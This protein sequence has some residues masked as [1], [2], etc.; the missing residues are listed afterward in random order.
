MDKDEI[1]EVVMVGGSTKTPIVQQKVRDYF[2]GNVRV[3]C[4]FDPDTVV[5]YGATVYAGKLT[6]QAEGG[7]A[8][9]EITLTDVTPLNVGVIQTVEIP[10]NFLASIF[11]KAD[12]KTEMVVFMR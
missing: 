2:D 6:G 3:N 7:F 11:C 4:T 10:Q 1:N 9:D 5:A 8:A 12:I